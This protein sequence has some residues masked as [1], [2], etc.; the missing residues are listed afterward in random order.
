VT[1]TTHRAKPD[2]FVLAAVAWLLVGLVACRRAEPPATHAQVAAQHAS[3]IV[4]GNTAAAEFLAF[5]LGDE[6]AQRIAALPEQVDAY[7][8]FDFRRAPWN[9]PQRFARY[10]PEAL[11]ALHP[12]LVVTHDWQSR[13]TTQILRAQGIPLVVLASA[14]S[15]DDVRGTLGSLGRTLGVDAR[16]KDAIAGLDRRVEKLR[17]GSSGRKSLRALEYSNSGTGGMTAGADTTAETMIVLA[18]M[19]NAAAEAGLKGHVPL[20]L[21]KL[22]SIDPDVIVVGAP[23]RDEV[24]SPTKS[25]LEKTPALA[26]L[27]AVKSGRIAVLPSALLSSDS[28][29]LVEAAER[30]AAEVD[31]L[32][33][34]ETA[35]ATGR[36]R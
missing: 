11:I 2:V 35:G 9:A 7:S 29:C 28:P 19:R 33:A 18:G 10:A 5:L 25:V 32:V 6:G 30:L 3:R 26:G 15:Y 24:G 23:A 4:A 12:D 13:D 27:S 8:S 36:D 17:Q 16:A 34:R 14:R 20:D 22:V 21:E 1:C 31:A